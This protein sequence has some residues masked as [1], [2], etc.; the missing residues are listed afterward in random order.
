LLSKFSFVVFFPVAALVMAGIHFAQRS[1]RSSS[2]RLA[3]IAAAAVLAFVMVWS[4]Y[5]FSVGVLDVGMRPAWQRIAIRYRIPAPQFFA[6]LHMVH[7]HSVAGHWAYLFGESRRHGWWYYFPVV[8]FFKTPL[9]FL[10]ASAAGIVRMVR[11]RSA[12]A[13]GVAIAPMAMLVP[14]M[15]SGINI[16]VRHVLPMFPLLTI[17]AACAVIAL[18]RWSRVAVIV[19]LAWYFVATALAHPD[20]MSYFNEAACGHPERIAANSNLDWG[21]DLLRLADVV[22]RERIEH[23]Y[24]AYSGSADWQRFVPQGRQL[25]PLTPVHGWVAISENERVFL[26]PTAD[27]A[28]YAWL[29]AYKPVRR[30]GKSIWLYRIP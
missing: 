12:E 15:A 19:L 3:Q 4:A 26:W 1:D 2:L 24:V 22:R 30:V 16:G 17:C 27:Q 11:S 10:V 14:A 6:G 7:R 9:A 13:A 29:R 18:W 5:K 21:Q 28:P 8:I 23:L 25:P 20:Y